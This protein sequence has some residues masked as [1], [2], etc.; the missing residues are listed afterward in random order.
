MTLCLSLRDTEMELSDKELKSIFECVSEVDGGSFYI[1][2]GVFVS[3]V[4]RHP[5]LAAI[6]KEVWEAKFH[7]QVPWSEDL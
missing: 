4:R 7:R 1:A 3:I 6:A 2:A 5:Q